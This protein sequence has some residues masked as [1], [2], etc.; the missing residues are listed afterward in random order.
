MRRLHG[1]AG[2]HAIVVCALAVDLDRHAPWLVARRI[3]AFWLTVYDS[4]VPGVA[5]REARRS[6][7]CASLVRAIAEERAVES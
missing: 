5:P 1:V 2:R 4:V 7:L 3:D 6:P